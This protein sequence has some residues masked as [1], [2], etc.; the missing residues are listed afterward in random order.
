MG[1]ATTAKPVL[2]DQGRSPGIAD[3]YFNAVPGFDEL[4]E[5]S[6]QI[7]SH[8][9]ERKESA[10]MKTRPI[11]AMQTRS[12]DLDNG[13]PAGLQKSDIPARD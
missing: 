8:R 6:D 13:I 4:K 5:S 9:W 12:V 7:R 2:L 1:T 11:Y 10:G 3:D